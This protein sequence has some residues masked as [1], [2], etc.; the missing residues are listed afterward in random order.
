MDRGNARL[1]RTAFGQ[2]V[3]RFTDP[4]RDENRGSVALV[5]HIRMSKTGG[6]EPDSSIVGCGVTHAGW[7]GEAVDSERD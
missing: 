6:R 7:F 2:N 1:R 4:L 3:V 5:E